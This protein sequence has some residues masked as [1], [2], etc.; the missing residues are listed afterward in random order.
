M[1]SLFYRACETRTNNM[2]DLD[3]NTPGE[4]LSRARGEA[5]SL[6]VFGVDIVFFFA[7][8]LRRTRTALCVFPRVRPRDYLSE[9]S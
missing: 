4:D 8:D 6:R 5:C 2:R 9:G 7:G 1:L 3:M